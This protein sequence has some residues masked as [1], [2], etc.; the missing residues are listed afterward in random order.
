MIS[1]I[2]I[3]L[4]LVFVCIIGILIWNLIVNRT[5]A[6]IRLFTGVIILLSAIALY[7]IIYMIKNGVL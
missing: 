1:I 5:N 2:D 4:I 6:I 3:A 7:V